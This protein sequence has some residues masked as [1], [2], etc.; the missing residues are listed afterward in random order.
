[1][2]FLQRFGLFGYAYTTAYAMA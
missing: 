2:L 1:M